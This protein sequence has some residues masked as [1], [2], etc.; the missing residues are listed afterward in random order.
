MRYELWVGCCLLLT[1]PLSQAAEEAVTGS[2]FMKG[3]ADQSQ[4][5][6]LPVRTVTRMRLFDRQVSFRNDNKACVRFALPA[7]ARVASNMTLVLQAY[8]DDRSYLRAVWFEVDGVGG[9]LAVH[10]VAPGQYRGDGTIAPHEHKTWQ[11]PLG[12]VPISRKGAASAEVDFQGMLQAP[13]SHTLCS[14]ISTYREYGP[15]SWITLEL[16]AEGN[17]EAPSG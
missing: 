12:R 8:N 10:S 15:D 2:Y 9:Y 13:G 14:W 17:S 4:V 11:L 1:V 6:S 3:K 7:P 5:V 16:V